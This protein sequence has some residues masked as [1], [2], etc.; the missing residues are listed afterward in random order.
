[1]VW[2][3]SARV[4][5]RPEP[6]VAD[7]VAVWT[8]AS[9]VAVGRVVS[10]EVEVG[11]TVGDEVAVGEGELVEVGVELAVGAGVAVSTGVAVGATADVGAAV[12]DA[13]KRW[14][15]GTDTVE[16]AE[17]QA[18]RSVTTRKP[19]KTAVCKRRWL[20]KPLTPTLS[21]GERGLS[22]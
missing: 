11:D 22:R 15:A 4:T 7:R 20:G 21:R 9:G 12:G 3:S 10:V 19:P 16:G 8:T 6:G 14:S 18:T 1:M 13:A 17:L 2:P 5:M